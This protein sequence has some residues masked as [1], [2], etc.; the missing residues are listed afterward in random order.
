MFLFFK[1]IT[2]QWKYNFMGQNRYVKDNIIYVIW[3]C[4]SSNGKHLR[5]TYRGLFYWGGIRLYD[6]K[7]GLRLT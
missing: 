6:D 1:K 4:H 5:R 3:Q 2:N 7:D